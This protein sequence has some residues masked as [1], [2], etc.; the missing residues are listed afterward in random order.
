MYFILL[1]LLPLI[2][3]SLI[4]SHESRIVAFAGDEGNGSDSAGEGEG[5]EHRY[6]DVQHNNDN[7]RNSRQATKKNRQLV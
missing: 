1:C 7:G 3:Q 2:N 6:Y 4:N 5:E